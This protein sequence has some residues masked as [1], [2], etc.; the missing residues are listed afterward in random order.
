MDDEKK[1]QCVVCRRMFVRGR[2]LKIHQAKSGCKERMTASHRR[3][4]K[5]EAN[6]TQE[7]HHS[8]ADGHVELSESRSNSTT[9]EEVRERKRD[10]EVKDKEGSDRK[11]SKPERKE[12]K[13]SHNR[14]SKKI[15]KNSR[16]NKVLKEKENFQISDNGK[17][18]KKEINK[19]DGRK[20]DILKLGKKE[21]FNN[22]EEKPNKVIVKKIEELLEHMRKK[23]IKIC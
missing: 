21:I 4:C 3:L 10:G 23:A 9:R 16:K 5:S 14:G 11:L 2:G 20:E 22:K 7:L 6:S 8:D 12:G 15:K 19:V 13:E 18:S 17:R 1:E